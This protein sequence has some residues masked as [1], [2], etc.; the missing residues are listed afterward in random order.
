[1]SLHADL[2]T[3]VG[4][5]ALH[6]LPDDERALFEA[7]LRGCR[8]RAEEVEELTATTAELAAATAITPPPAM[9]RHVLMYAAMIRQVSP[10]LRRLTGRAGGT[11]LPSVAVAACLIAAAVFGADTVREHHRAQEATAAI[12]QVQRQT[13]RLSAILGA[14]DANVR[15]T[16]LPDGAHLTV[17]LTRD[18]E[19]AVLAAADLPAPSGGKVYELWYVVGG[20]MRP[21]ALLDPHHTGQALVLVGSASATSAVGLTLEPAGG[22]THH[23]TS[24]LLTLL[25]LP[26]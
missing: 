6:A 18:R 24:G 11:G 22:S 3:L 4:A 17:T 13:D 10:S 23:P 2:R 20:T 26:T 19:Q 16:E 7:R 5:Y 25:V 8:A 9:R 12:R 1:M 21:A 15:K 14:P